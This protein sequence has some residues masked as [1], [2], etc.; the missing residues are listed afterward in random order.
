[1]ATAQ[2]RICLSDVAVAADVSV[3]TVS[4][5]LNGTGQMTAETRDRVKRLAEELGLSP[6]AMAHALISQRSLTVGLITNDSY[7]DSSCR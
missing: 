7:G 3:A 1:M 5:A 4:K 6:N 2:V